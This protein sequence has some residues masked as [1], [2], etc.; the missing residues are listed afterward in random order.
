M[1]TLQ[2]AIQT[3]PPALL[4][5]TSGS[6]NLSAIMPVLE[7]LGLAYESESQIDKNGQSFRC[8]SLIDADETLLQK[9][10]DAIAQSGNQS[11]QN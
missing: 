10:A 5:S 9:N 3:Q 1:Q 6:L 7:N 8:Y 11:S 4:I 2:V